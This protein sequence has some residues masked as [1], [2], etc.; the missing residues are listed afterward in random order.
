MTFHCHI[1]VVLLIHKSFFIDPV[2]LAPLLNKVKVDQIIFKAIIIDESTEV[3]VI[4]DFKHKLS[5][6]V[7]TTTALKFGPDKL[8]SNVIFVFIVIIHFFVPAL[9]EIAVITH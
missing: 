2:S 8:H 7:L 3:F 1:I 4:I 5:R 6:V 9:L